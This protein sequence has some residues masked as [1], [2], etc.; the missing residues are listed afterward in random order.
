MTGIATVLFYISLYTHLASSYSTEGFFAWLW[1]YFLALSK[2]SFCPGMVHSMN[3]E[4][5]TDI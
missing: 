2:G 1:P 5:K 4:L 3:L